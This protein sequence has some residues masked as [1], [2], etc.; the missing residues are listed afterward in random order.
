MQPAC[1][2]QPAR[3]PQ[4]YGLLTPVDG[5]YGVGTQVAARLKRLNIHTLQDLVFHFPIRYQDR[6]RVVP[7][8]GLRPG[9]EAL[10]QGEVLMTEVAA[11]R[12]PTLLTR[13]SDGTG[14][15]TLRFFHFTERQRAGLARN[16]FVRCYGEVRRGLATLEMVHPEYRILDDCTAA[17]ET[18]LT[19]V[20]PITEGLHQGTLRSLIARALA[21]LRAPGAEEAWYGGGRREVIITE[22]LPEA[23]LRRR[24]WPGVVAAL[25]YIHRP[26]VDAP[27][28]ALNEA[29]HPAYQRLAF[30]ELLA[31]HLGLREVRQRVAQHGAPAVESSGRLMGELLAV[32]P[33]TL[34]AAQRRVIDEVVAD[35]R[36][37]TPMQ[38][39]VQGDV[40]SG[41]TAV[42]A[43][44][45]AHVV[46]A[47]RQVAVMAPTELLAEQHF[48]TFTR[49]FAPLGVEV[50][51]LAG[52]LKGAGRRD[53]LAR[54]HSGACAVAV[55]THALFQDEVRFAN[56]GLT[57]VDEQHRFGV[58]QRLAL[59]EKGRH[60]DH[61]P[62]QLIMTATPIPRTLAMT[63]YADLD[64]SVIDEL[65]AGRTPV[66]TVAV[67]ERRRDEVI[68]RI[69][70]ACGQGRQAYWVCPLIEESQT[71]DCQSA[72][73]TWQQ[74]RESLPDLRV[75]LVHGRMKAREKE[76]VMHAFKA[77]EIQV[78]VATT[79][80]E[81]GVDVPN[82]TLMIIENA[83]RL[84]L[85]QLHQ[86]RGRVG[87]GTADSSCVLLYRAPLSR[88]GRA[89]LTILRDT[90]DGFEIA[91]RDLELRGPGEVMGTR[92]TGMLQF[93]VADLARDKD[94]VSMI[95]EVSSRLHLEAPERI[96]A[97]IQRWLGDMTQYGSV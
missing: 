96:P 89:R 38:R 40:G 66:L 75:G 31:H 91:R 28:D 25:S 39:L 4:R 84:G 52:R 88:T 23:L 11:G 59:L 48:H 90:R 22:L 1:N 20:Y 7:M 15:V 50:Q 92:Q 69:R 74:L 67:S 83:E 71:L 46:E 80:I 77:G 97:L 54:L 33:Y 55:G 85:T 63:A 47:G 56:L 95:P 45:A 35:L 44:V 2:H 60:G 93:R 21:M 27:L 58:H 68:T 72:I 6:T 78:L 76:Q 42:A 62:H 14:S 37:R 61:Y 19:P 29:R 16:T 34:T 18:Q 36:R 87:R 53:V 86:L 10:V 73:D 12:R 5:L 43:A 30:E 57:V 13:I 32:L 26:P 65:P 3:Q 41:K 24:A 17:P 49:W 82:A 8:G 51:W 70:G 64:S 94:L 9:E 81:V 79:V